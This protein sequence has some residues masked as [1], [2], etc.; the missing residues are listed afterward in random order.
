MRD[1]TFYII[2]T[3]PDE[4]MVAL[5]QEVSASEAH[6]RAKKWIALGDGVL[7]VDVHEHGESFFSVSPTFDAPITDLPGSDLSGP[8][9]SEAER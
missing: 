7:R 1:F 2:R 5:V 3:A 8:D 9:L 6:R 4:P